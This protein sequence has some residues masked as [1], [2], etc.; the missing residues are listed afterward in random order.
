MKKIEQRKK[1]KEIKRRRLTD[2][3]EVVA[4]A[5][6]LS[7]AEVDPAS[8]G[9]RVVPLDVLD[10]EDR[11]TRERGAKIRSRAKHTGIRGVLR[12]G[13]RLLSGIDPA[14]SEKKGSPQRS[15]T[16]A[17]PVCLAFDRCNHRRFEQWKSRVG[18]CRDR[19]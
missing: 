1:E 4:E 2:D 18:Q 17:K 14:T 3:S 9:G 5:A 12:F 13:H 10:H 16:E 15:I 7:L 19:Q 6:S 8:V 11:R